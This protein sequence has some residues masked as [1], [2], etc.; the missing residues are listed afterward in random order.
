[1]RKDEIVAELYTASAEIGLTDAL[2]VA[3]GPT[4]NV[5]IYFGSISCNTRTD[6]LD[7]SVRAMNALKRAHS[8]V[9]PPASCRPK[10]WLQ[11]LDCSRYSINCRIM[12][13]TCSRY[14]REATQLRGG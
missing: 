1:M 5:C 7:F 8:S 11:K 9:H 12:F 6:E 10:M 13:F 4:V 2:Y 14:F 3:F